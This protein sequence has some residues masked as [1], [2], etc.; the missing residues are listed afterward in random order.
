MISKNLLKQIGQLLGENIS[1]FNVSPV[2]G[3]D[4][5]SAYK[6]VTDTGKQ[7]FVKVN[8]REF[9]NM[10]CQEEFG[11]QTIEKAVNNSTPKTIAKGFDSQLSYL[12]L[13]YLNPTLKTEYFWSQLATKLAQLHKIT[14]EQFGFESNNFIGT[15]D[16]KNDFH[17]NW[18]DFFVDCRLEPQIEKAF[19]QG[20]ISNKLIA[21]FNY[22][23]AELDSI[24]PVEKPALV[25]GDLW[26][27]NIYCSN[28]SQA[29]FIDPSV[30][31]G[32][33][34]MDLAF[35]FMFGGFNYIFYET[36]KANFPIEPNF[37]KRRDFYNLYPT[38]VH[39]N[40]F[41]KSYLSPIERLLK[42]F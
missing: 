3:G 38:L 21:K 4:I 35:S 11:L 17:E 39:L 20:L 10:F 37:D 7:F 28:N 15:L 42:S 27:G 24:F 36:Y 30:Y 25:H 5:N 22:L 6:F 9:Y 8:S 32:H 26:S 31:Y 33:R 13:E 14:N 2:S 41:G 34:E 23:F 16:Q 1:T 18:T 29:Y 19:N 40:L 12:V